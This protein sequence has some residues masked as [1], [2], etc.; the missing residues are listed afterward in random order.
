MRGAAL[1]LAVALG[2]AAP[3]ARAHDIYTGVHGRDGQLCCGGSDCAATTYRMD[4]GRYFFAKREG[5]EIELPEERITF[6]P[7]PGEDYS[8]PNGAHL[9]YRAATDSDRLGPASGNVF[10]DVFL[11]CAFIPPGSI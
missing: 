1:A 7:I 4:H 5:G 10:G 2:V 3:P 9:C 6:L 8:R 11:Y